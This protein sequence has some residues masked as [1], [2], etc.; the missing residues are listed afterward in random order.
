M[1]N[2]EKYI[3]QLLRKFMDGTS[4]VDE[5][6]TIGQWFRDHPDGGDGLDDYRAMFSWFDDGM[7][8]GSDN[9]IANG[10]GKQGPMH[11]PVP[12][13][14]KRR[15]LWSCIA[16]AASAALLVGLFLPQGNAPVPLAPKLAVRTVENDTAGTAT[17]LPDEGSVVTSDTINTLN[18]KVKTKDRKRRRG[19]LRFEP[20]LPPPYYTSDTVKAVTTLDAGTALASSDGVED[21]RLIDEKTANKIIDCMVASMEKDEQLQIELLNIRNELKGKQIL[22]TLD[23]DIY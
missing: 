9:N 10:G 13:S 11:A 15:W 2:D 1:N 17:S 19:R 23:D 22:A 18:N 20:V 3:R 4:T 7:P 14:N 8:L 5:E 6:Q 12:R 21:E 16:V